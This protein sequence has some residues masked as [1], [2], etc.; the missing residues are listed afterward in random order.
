MFEVQPTIFSSDEN[1]SK[2]SIK[3]DQQKYKFNHDVYFVEGV[4]LDNSFGQKLPFQRTS[5]K[6]VTCI[7]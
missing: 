5:A 6:R 2:Q 7:R 1:T 4:S 3:T